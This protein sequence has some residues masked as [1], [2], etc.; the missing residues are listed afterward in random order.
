MAAQQRI[1][2]DATL[3]FD[4]IRKLDAD[5]TYKAVRISKAP[6]DITAGSTHVKLNRG[7]LR[8]DPLSLDLPQGRMGGWIQL[9]GRGKDAV[10]DRDLRLS[11]ARL[12]HIVTINFQGTQP[13]AGPLVGRVKLHGVGDSVHD[14]IGDADGQA[15]MVAPGGEIRRAMAE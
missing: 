4:R 3:D 5:V 15:V 9:N 12:E 1:F 14:A 6:I 13:V 10:T 7:L 2:P 11:N 8:A